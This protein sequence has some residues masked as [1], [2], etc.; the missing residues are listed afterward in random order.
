MIFIHESEIQYHGNLKSANCLV[1]SRWVLQVSD[2]GLQQ[3]IGKDKSEGDSH[4]EGNYH[5]STS[6]ALE[7]IMVF[8]L[9]VPLLLAYTWIWLWTSF[10]YYDP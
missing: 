7:Y 2:F 9:I 3:L 8:T 1:D 10:T 6:D 4:C 5:T